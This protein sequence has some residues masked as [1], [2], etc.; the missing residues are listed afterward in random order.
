MRRILVPFLIACAVLVTAVSLHAQGTVPAGQSIV[1]NLDQSVSSKDAK[2]GQT[3]A[4]SVAADVTVDGKTIIPRGA[5]AMLSVATA[6]PSGRLKGTSK[7]WLRIDSLEVGGK[8]YTVDSATTGQNGPSHK[9]RDVVAIG[10][11]AGAGAIIGAIAGGGKGAAIGAGVGAAAG[12]VGAAATGK[13]EVTYPAES[14]LR[15]KLKSNL[16][17]DRPARGK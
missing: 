14:K 9:N 10:G 12:T 1:I 11:G 4:G 15:F 5:K 13:K 17:I 8:S 6:E 16:N 7:L 2:V 3:V